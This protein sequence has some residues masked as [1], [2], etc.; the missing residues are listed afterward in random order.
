[1]PAD[2]SAAPAWLVTG[3]STGIGREI[4][5][6]ALEK[7]YRVAVTARDASR[8][9]ALAA[10]FPGRSLPLT[11]D[12]TVP[13]QVREA[14]AEAEATL[15]GLD[16]LVN[17]AGYGYVSAVEEGEDAEIRAMFETNYFG[18]ISM[19]KAVLPGMRSRRR[20]HII[21]ISSMTGLIGNPGVA[22]YSSS[23][24]ALEG[25]SEALSK[26]MAPLGIK[27]L[28]VEPGLFRT[29]WASRS[30]RE[31]RQPIADYDATVGARRAMIRSSHADHH[32]DPRRV[33][34]AVVMLAELEDPPLR[35]LVGR[36]AYEA[37]REKLQGLDES[38]SEWEAFSCSEEGEAAAF[39]ARDDRSASD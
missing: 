18:V 11:L 10:R 6:A 9:E 32:A 23:K 2:E 24:F 15:G 26:E 19:I 37:Y 28:L 36:D 38:L 29:D 13:E 14:V 16:V 12:V 5:R 22:Y 17:N 33:G 31:T 30:M 34:D 4:A 39:P 8:V 7:G 27:V 20:G 25:L 21:N 1:M 35:L 3:C